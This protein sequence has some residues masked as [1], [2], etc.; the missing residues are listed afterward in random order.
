MD[1]AYLCKTSEKILE[2]LDIK[3]DETQLEFSPDVWPFILRPLG[4]D[5]GIRSLQRTLENMAR[6]VAFE[7]VDQKK[8]KVVI[9]E[10][11]FQDYLPK[12]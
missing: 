5:S 4:F 11:N 3:L 8:E 6:K 7:I 10:L 1:K 9:N 12:Y 2:H